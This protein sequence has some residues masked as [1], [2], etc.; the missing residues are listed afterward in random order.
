MHS[1]GSIRRVVLVATLVCLIAPA[2][3]EAQ[4]NNR[5][6]RRDLVSDGGVP[7][8]QVDPNLINAWGLAP[9]PTGVG[10]VNAA[11]AGL[12]LLYNGEGGKTPLEVA[13][14]GEP[15]G[16][17]F[18]GGAAFVVPGAGPGRFLF[19]SEDGTI[20]AWSPAHAP[21]TEAVVMVDNSATGAIYKGLAIDS[22]SAGSTIYAADFHNA[23]IDV[24][25]G[26]F[27][28]VE[29]LL[30][31]FVDPDLPEGYAPFNIQ[32]LA[33]S[34][35]VTYALQDKEAEEEVVGD[36]L[37]IVDQ[38]DFGGT[39]IARVATGGALNAPWGLALAPA[40][41]GRFSG[42]LLVGNF[43]DGRINAYDPATFEPRGHLKADGRH[44][45]VID[46][47]WGIAFGNGAA[48]G[49]TNALFFAAGPDDEEHGL[50]GR[51][52]PPAF[53]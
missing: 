32:A 27:T 16:I 25:D 24:F 40:N 45:I 48:A 35:Y 18:N 47:L 49:P 1:F 39:L 26:N 22:T 44:A 13:V 33:G 4:K 28:Q 30:P 41:F 50:F 42:D 2:F 34:L 29:S 23:R 20:S 9:N 37:G 52:D 5:Y 19:A 51:L 43:G 12:T 21:I 11:D 15:T 53:P 31:I 14:Q 10:W 38:Y 36:G 6:A 3:V 8:E 46:G 7:A 17:V